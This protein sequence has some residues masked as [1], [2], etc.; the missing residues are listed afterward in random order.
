LETA[1]AR[2]RKQIL[3]WDKTIE[4]NKNLATRSTRRRR[5]YPFL[6][7]TSSLAGRKVGARAGREG[8]VE[9][10]GC[11]EEKTLTTLSLITY[12]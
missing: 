8:E 4:A 12:T 2:A 3:Q 5:P 10:K 9:S 11:F 7:P 1:A 6:L